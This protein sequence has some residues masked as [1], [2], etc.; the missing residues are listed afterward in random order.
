LVF[1]LDGTAHLTG[2]RKFAVSRD[3]HEVAFIENGHA[4]GE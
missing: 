2:L 3:L 1:R 4:S